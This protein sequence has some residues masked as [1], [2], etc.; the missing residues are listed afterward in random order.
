[1]RFNC[2]TTFFQQSSFFSIVYLKNSQAFHRFHSFACL[3]HLPWS[4]FLSFFSLLS[5]FSFWK[6]KKIKEKE[7][8][9]L[10]I[11]RRGLKTWQLNF[12]RKIPFSLQV[13]SLFL[14]N[15]LKIFV[16][17]ENDDRTDSQMFAAFENERRPSK[18]MWTCSFP[19][20]LR[21][22]KLTVWKCSSNIDVYIEF[23][24]PIEK[25]VNFELICI[26]F[27]MKMMDKTGWTSCSRYCLLLRQ[28]S[29]CLSFNEPWK[30]RTT[31]WLIVDHWK[32]ES[33]I[34]KSIG[35]TIIDVHLINKTIERRRRGTNCANVW[36]KD[37]ISS[38]FY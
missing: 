15:H 21:C 38:N 5:R 17:Q 19:N 2:W 30:C 13:M 12:Q 27:R 1:M 14:E 33:I 18:Q 3:F 37:K 34:S 11:F 8:R 10:T 28:C 31:T 36:D 6:Q 25:L 35:Q 16:E 29:R 22:W 4:S 9:R 23:V 24:R 32:N 20:H 26:F 7:N